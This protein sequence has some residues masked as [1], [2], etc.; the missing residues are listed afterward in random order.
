VKTRIVF[1]AVAFC[2]LSTACGQGENPIDETGKA[3]QRATKSAGK[4]ARKI[5]KEIPDKKIELKI[6]AALTGEKEFAGAK[7]KAKSVR[8]IV[9][10]TGTAPSAAVKGKIYKLVKAIKG[11]RKVKNKI[12]VTRAEKTE[13]SPASA[14]AGG[15]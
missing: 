4:A 6:L 11:V 3:V 15:K 7:V 10:L 2:V 13:P 5:V 9:T 1:V 8:G 12:T 14:P